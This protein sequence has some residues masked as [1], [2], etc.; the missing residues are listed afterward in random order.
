MD[1]D[2]KEL[3]KLTAKEKAWADAYLVTF[4]KAG[5]ARIAKYKGDNKTLAHVG[6]ENYRKAH[7]Q[8]YMKERL[9]QMAMSAEEALARLGDMASASLA[10][11]TD[12]ELLADLKD[13][14]K[15]YLIKHLTSDV[16]EDKAGKLHYK[17]RFE[18]HDAQ[19][20]IEDILKIH[21]KFT[22]KLEHSGTVEVKVEYTNDW[23]D[24][25]DSPAENN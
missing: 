10:D 13:H 3:A 6:W 23:R 7:I 1:I 2:S 22:D 5:A 21:G 12:V 4:S 24:T 9:D 11:F 25:G 15:A 18:L 14:P 16:Y 17:T 19:R 8:A 20:A